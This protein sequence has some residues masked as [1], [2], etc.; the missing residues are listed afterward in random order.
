MILGAYQVLGAVVLLGS[1]AFTSCTSKAWVDNRNSGAALGTSY[2]IQYITQGKIDL[3]EEIDSVFAAVNK[4]MSTYI[5][6]SDISKINDGDTTVIVDAMFREVFDISEYVYGE[7]NGYFDPTVG[8]L[9]NAWGFGP[10]GPM[11]LDSTV[12]D[13]LLGF[14]GF[15]KVGLTP[16]NRVKVQHPGVYFDFNAVAKGY[17]I[18]CLARVMDSHGIGDYLIEVG[19]ELIGRGSNRVKGKPWTVGIEDPQVLE[20]RKIKA[21]LHLI[22][23][24]MATSG[25][26]RKFRIDP[27]TGMKYV[28]T[29]DPKTGY[30]RVSNTLSASVLANTCGKADAFATAFMA[31]P[32]E[33]AEAVLAGHPELDGYII[34]LDGQGQVQE[35]VT[36]GFSA[37][38]VSAPRE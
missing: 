12:V 9:V 18:D 14:V 24:A 25:N 31:M 37:A 30:T 16:E 6:D 19:G 35:F 17:T 27:D 10:E 1:F 33:M 22:D 21:T 15:D 4:S 5:P 29:I 13:S 3:Q 7:S 38:L 26:Y 32:L 28:H 11:V 2:N 8:V 36:S 34:Y 23:R 20:E